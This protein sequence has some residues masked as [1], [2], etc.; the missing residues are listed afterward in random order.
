[1]G[2]HRK[3]SARTGY[4]GSV[5]V[6]TGLVP[7]CL[8]AF[9]GDLDAEMLT[10]VDAAAPAEPSPVEFATIPVEFP[11]APLESLRDAVQHDPEPPPAEPA[12]VPV[13]APVAAADAPTWRHP[14]AATG[15]GVV[16]VPAAA[17]A[18][19]RNAADILADEQPGCH[20]TWTLLGG[21][22]RIESDHAFGGAVD[23]SGTTTKPIYGPSLDGSTAGNAV[24]ADTDDG[25][26]D[27]LA[28]HDRAVGPMQFIPGTWRHYA[29]DGNGNGIAD[30]N[31][32]FDA[33]LGAGR[34]LCDGGLDMADG[35]QRTRAIL[36]Y[37]NSMAYVMNVMA[38]EEAYR[39]G[40]TPQRSE[41]P[42]I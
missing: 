35:D 18:A 39:T 6:L 25:A 41:L 21:I 33:A 7:T 10:A 42:P 38:W 40:S 23:E 5:I 31:N 3:H 1:M 15:P 11:V 14:V 16:S 8:P 28:D 26:V 12:P 19:Y 34:Y 9:G 37:N 32:L 20:L 30:A 36:R 24:I 22:G 4:R 2:R 29:A 27:G 17:V 13:A